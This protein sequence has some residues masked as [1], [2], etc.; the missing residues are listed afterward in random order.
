MHSM[1]HVALQNSSY[2]ES[3]FHS[4]PSRLQAKRYGAGLPRSQVKKLR[5]LVWSDA[6]RS[7]IA[8][9]LHRRE[10]KLRTDIPPLAVVKQQC[11]VARCEFKVQLT[12]LKFWPSCLEVLACQVSKGNGHVGREG[13]CFRNRVNNSQKS[14]K[15]CH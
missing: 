10:R 15:V 12:L 8:S 3:S 6:T 2:R 1:F 5:P 13:A 14:F 7:G 9:H 11:Q 4:T